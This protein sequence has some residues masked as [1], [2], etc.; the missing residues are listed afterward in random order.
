MSEIITIGLASVMI[1]RVSCGR[2]MLMRPVG[3]G[4]KAIKVLYM[5]L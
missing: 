3:G 5:R 1:V 2:T 4:L